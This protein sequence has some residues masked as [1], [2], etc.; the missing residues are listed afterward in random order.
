MIIVAVEGEQEFRDQI[1]CLRLR[2]PAGGDVGLVEGQ[3]LHI[4]A[5]EGVEA[6]ALQRTD[7]LAAECQRIQRFIEA[8]R[9]VPR[10]VRGRIGD[11]GEMLRLGTLCIGGRGEFFRHLFERQQPGHGRFEIFPLRIGRACQ[12]SFCLFVK[13]S[14]TMTEDRL[15][16]E[17]EMLARV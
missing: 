2:H 1:I 11:A 6:H 12:L 13:S 16:V 5:A 15:I 17:V 8:L 4:R 14:Q 3:Q 9:R 7:C 10:A